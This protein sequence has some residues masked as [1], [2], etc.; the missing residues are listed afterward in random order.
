[1]AAAWEDLGDVVI[2]DAPCSGQSLLGR[3][4]ESPGCFHPATINMNSN[5]QKRI[6]ANSAAVVSPGGY[7]AYLTCTYSMKENEE[8]VRW[9]LKKFPM[10]AP[11]KVD[12]LAGHESCY[13]EFPCYRLWPHDGE[14]AGGFAAILKNHDT[15]NCQGVNRGDVQVLWQSENR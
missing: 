12:A 4:K 13:C 7:L 3:G 8:V 2:V 11:Q 9:F 10:F 1:L 5:R 6:L 14:G 15:A